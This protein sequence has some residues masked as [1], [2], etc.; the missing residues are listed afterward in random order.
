[1]TNHPDLLVGINYLDDAAVYRLTDDIALVQTIDFFTPIVDDP[2]DFGRIAAANA[3]SDVYAMGGKPITAM[4]VVAFPI[5]K[6]DKNI[7]KKILKGGYDKVQEAGALLVGGHS[8]EDSDIKYGLSVTGIVHPNEILTNAGA[9]PGDRLV[10]TKPIGTGIIATALKGG[11]AS[12]EALAKITE[13]MTTLNRV[14]SEVT[15]EIGVNACT[16]ITGFGF[17]G[18]AVE[19]ATASDVGISI[20]WQSVPFFPEAKEYASIGM[21]PGGT[22]RNREFASCRV[23]SPGTIPPA[24]VD[25]L[26]D[27]QT[28]GGL[29]ISVAAEKAQGLLERLHSRGVQHAAVVGEVMEAPKGGIVV[30]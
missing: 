8:I 15:L 19:M 26:Y 27:A 11:K 1:V 5:K 12:Q 6:M 16:D 23:E 3:L 9:R 2:F 10:L 30:S 14:A 24:I 7:L 4:N 22:G 13:S 25:I 21:V 18:H 20:H 29:L 28:S 17:L